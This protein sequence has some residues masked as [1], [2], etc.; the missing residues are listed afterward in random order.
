MKDVCRASTLSRASRAFSP[1]KG[2]LR[3]V[4]LLLF[5]SLFALSFVC[6]L[7]AQT[8]TGTGSIVGIASDP[9][10]AV[11][12]LAKVTITNLATGRAIDLTTN[13]AGAFNSGALIPGNYIA[14]FSAKGFSS[15]EVAATVFLGNT[16]TVNATLQVGV[17]KT[18]IDVQGYAAA[19]NTEQPTVQGVLTEQQIDSLPVSG[20]NVLDL[21]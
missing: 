16:A 7:S 14:R 1:A 19:V 4:A 11:I 17:E 21:A 9:S 18:T 2:H 12:S 20:R 15:V 13:S 10:G 6:T 8:T 3:T 5:L